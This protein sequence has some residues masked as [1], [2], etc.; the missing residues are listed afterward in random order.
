MTE[1]SEKP[2]TSKAQTPFQRFTE[3]AKI[4]FSPAKAK[5]ISKQVKS[6]PKKRK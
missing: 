4:A 1:K 5:Q 3:A 6:V 2:T